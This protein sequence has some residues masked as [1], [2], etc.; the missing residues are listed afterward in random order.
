MTLHHNEVH[1]MRL[2]S[3][4]TT[5][6]LIAVIGSTAT[7]SSSPSSDAA[8][9]VS[10]DNCGTSTTYAEAPKRAFTMNQAATEIMLALGLQDRMVG[11][12]FL[13]D[14]VLPEFAEAYTRIRVRATAY[15]SR[16]MLL[17]TRPDFI[18][19]AYKSAFSDELPGMRELLQ[20]GTESYLSPSDC[21]NPAHSSSESTDMVFDEIRDIARIFGVTSRAEQLIAGY[22]SDL[23]AIRDRIGQVATAPR[24]FWWDS[25]LPPYV[26]GCCG[27]PNEIMRLSGAQNIFPDLR[28]T[29]G[30]VSWDD[31]IE[32]NPEVIVLVDASWASAAQKRQFLQANAIFAGIDAVKHER[33][34]TVSFSDA[35]P[36]IRNIAAARRVAEALY[37]DKFK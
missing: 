34:V 14:E 29:W 37:P 17:A 19:A 8:F 18:Y 33:F 23:A 35:T 30:T 5:I 10:V 6:A 11:T 36:G 24:V 12:A 7:L 21:T 15:P 13:D 22:R 32:R 25:G 16:E 20:S 28:G 26:A 3:L 2:T 4:T 27:T 31:V 9:P 1:S